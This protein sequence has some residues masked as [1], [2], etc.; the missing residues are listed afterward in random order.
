[1]TQLHLFDPA[2]LPAGHRALLSHYASARNLSVSQDQLYTAEASRKGISI[3]ELK[4][5]KPIGKDAACHSAGTRQVRWWQQDLKQK[6][7]LEPVPGNRGRW[8]LTEPARKAL[9]PQT[10]G[11]VMLGYSTDLGVALWANCE[12][13]MGNL[14]EPITLMLSS[15]PYALAAPRAYGNVPLSAYVDWLC[16]MLEPVVKRLRDGGVIA[17]NVTNDCFERGSPARSTYRERLVIALEDRFH[18]H[19]MDELIWENK[20]KPPGPI[21]WASLQRFQLNT[22]WEPVYV[23]TNNPHRCVANN[24]RV[25]QQHTQQHLALLKNGGEKRERSNSDGAYRIYPGSFGNQ[26]AGRIPKNVLS[27]VH[28]AK[29][30]DL[31]RAKAAASA[32]G[33]PTHGA[34]MPLALADFL[35]QYLSD[36]GSLVVDPFGGWGTTGYAAEINGRRWVTTEKHLEYVVGSAE[37]FSSFAG[38]ESFQAPIQG[39]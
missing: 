26:T 36:E 38:F 11:R 33:L 3:D 24:R 35:V 22:S 39:G 12:D 7:W 34:P 37:R 29:D 8:R 15:P 19:K 23:F 10:P 1:M 9:L 28:S 30:P 14:D 17:L 4:S 2:A 25:L 21:Q 32:A 18:L 31:A 13:V 20:T 27:Y 6:G 16:Q 5:R